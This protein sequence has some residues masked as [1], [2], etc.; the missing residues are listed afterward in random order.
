[1][2]LSASV[3][4]HTS[5]W[6]RVRHRNFIFGIHM[7]ICLHIYAHQIF[8]DFL[9]VVCKWQP[10]WYF[11]LN[12]YPAHISSHRD[13]ISH[14]LK[15]LFFTYTLKRNNAT[16]TYFL[17]FMSIFFKNSY[18]PYFSEVS[19]ALTYAWPIKAMFYTLS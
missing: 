15:Y 1:M 19:C 17:K 6:H 18:T 16:V 13:F 11:S 12:C 14:I 2:S 9:I 7:H 4:V 3:S 10:F 8:S 5:P